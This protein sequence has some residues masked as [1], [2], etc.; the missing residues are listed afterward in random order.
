MLS[1]SW[2]PLVVAMLPGEILFVCFVVRV[3]LRPVSHQ[4]DLLPCVVGNFSNYSS[5][6]YVKHRQTPKLTADAGQT[7]V[8]YEQVGSGVEEAESWRVLTRWLRG[9]M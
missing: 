9:S 8:D 5:F 2:A 6:I 4:V 7:M 3:S 1:K